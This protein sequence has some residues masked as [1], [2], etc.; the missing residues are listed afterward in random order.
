LHASTYAQQS[1]AERS[2]TSN[3]NNTS[4]NNARALISPPCEV[5][6]RAFRIVAQSRKQTQNNN[7]TKKTRNRNARERSKQNPRHNPPHQNRRAT[8]CRYTKQQTRIEHQPN[9]GTP[10]ARNQ[11]THLD[12]HKLLNPTRL[13][14]TT[15]PLRTPTPPNTRTQKPPDATK[16]RTRHKYPDQPTALDGQP[17]P[18]PTQLGKL[19]RL[20]ESEKSAQLCRIRVHQVRLKNA[21]DSVYPC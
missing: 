1:Q 3:N 11:P 16:T 8:N 2:K 7:N 15:K 5:M 19:D 6:A 17:D 20:P 14:P 21:G 13:N 9:P 4:D 10:L 18:Q 12:D